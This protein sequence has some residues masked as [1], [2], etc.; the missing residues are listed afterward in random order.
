MQGIPLSK[1]SA[2]LQDLLYNQSPAAH[3]PK[4]LQNLHY[5]PE[6]NS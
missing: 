5:L 6:E 4:L 3:R 2:F 1:R